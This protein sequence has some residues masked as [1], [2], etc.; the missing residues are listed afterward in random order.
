MV[1]L[2]LDRRQL[3]QVVLN[4]IVD[5]TQATENVADRR[6]E[7]DVTVTAAGTGHVLVAVGDTGP[8]L[9]PAV[10]PHI[11]EPLFTTKSEGSGM[12]LSICRSIIEAHG[13]RLVSKPKLPRGIVFQFQLPTDSQEAP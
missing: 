11:F 12:R 6:R 10:A 8:G 3:R 9:D 13:G 2:R 7:L 1:P 5:G 4:L